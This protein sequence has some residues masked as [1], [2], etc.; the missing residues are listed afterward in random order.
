MK[1]PEMPAEEGLLEA[2]ETLLLEISGMFWSLLSSSR[3]LAMRV[4]SLCA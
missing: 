1:Q 2:S 4:P 3:C